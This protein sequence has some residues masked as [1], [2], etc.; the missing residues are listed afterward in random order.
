MLLE[1]K[2]YTNPVTLVFVDSVIIDWSVKRYVYNETGQH[3]RDYNTVEHA[4][5]AL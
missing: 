1:I 4:R 2:V 5:H 3:A